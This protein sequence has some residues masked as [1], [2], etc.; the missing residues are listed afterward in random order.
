MAV[1][2][3]PNVTQ[4]YPSLSLSLYTCQS[5][6]T[7][8]PYTSD[9]PETNFTVEAGSVGRCV[10]AERVSVHSSAAPFAVHQPAVSPL[11]MLMF[12]LARLVLGVAGY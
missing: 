4:Y 5:L 2:P 1:L 3:Q 10:R 7:H 6:Q 8:S 12:R 11:S 9:P